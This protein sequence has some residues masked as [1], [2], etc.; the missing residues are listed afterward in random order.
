MRRR[1][2]PPQAPRLGPALVERA[3]ITRIQQRIA[4]AATVKLPA[5]PAL[6]DHYA[7]TCA[8]LFAAAGR[9]FGRDELGAL[10]AVLGERLDAAFRMSSRSHVAIRF[11]APPGQPLGYEVTAEIRTLAD[12]YTRFAGA[13]GDSPF[14]NRADARV[15]DVAAELAS[16]T[17]G[18]CPVLDLGAGTGR[19]AFVLARLGHPVDAVEITPRFALTLTERAASEALGVR[20]LEAD[21]LRDPGPLRRDYRLLVASEVVPD[22]RDV[23]TLRSLFELAAA[24]LLDEGVLLFNVHVVV[25]GY[26]PDRATREF[27]Q[28]CYSMLF[29]ANEIAEAHGGLP[30]ELVANHAVHD[31][32][33]GRLPS[34]AWPPTPWFVNWVTGLDVYDV[35]PHESPI[36][37]RWLTF[38]KRVGCAPKSVSGARPGSARPYSEREAGAPRLDAPSL[39]RGVIRR[40]QRRTSASGQFTFPAVPGLSERYVA[41]CLATFEALGA[42]AAAE[43]AQALR[44][45]LETGSSHAFSQSSRSN[46]TV[47]YEVAADRPLRYGVTAEPVTLAAAYED[48]LEA[49]PWPLFGE[50]AD[51]R[52]LSLIEGVE[53]PEAARILDVGAGLGRNALALGRRGH[54]VDA[55]EMAPGFVTCLSTAVARERLPVRVLAGDF[56]SC[57]EELSPGYWMVLLSGVAGDFRDLAALRQALGIGSRLLAPGGVL[58][59]SIHVA[60]AG[61]IPNAVARAWGQQN[62]ALCV[63]PQELEGAHAGLGLELFADDPL[64]DY[65]RAHLPREAWP[66]TPVFAEWALGQHLYALERPQCP[67]EA[68][69]VVWRRRSPVGGG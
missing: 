66:P 39:R 68:R 3:L 28:Q 47:T 31:Y 55:I 17:P 62:A 4:T 38:R 35:S 2:K 19:N 20:V 61:Y 30:F 52:V 27:S 54:P 37:C 48:W 23:D 9:D 46:V 33:K 43:E 1:G 53:H 40:V 6:A 59:L 15:L 5:V 42:G 22:F 36:S 10:R 13:E 16:A 65:E 63:T 64:Y 50:H 21:V 41:V 12:D 51:A 58:V 18:G 56:F 49:S 14:G 7:Q 8:A 11:Y 44:C 45:A 57:S 25:G 24:V 29:T 34:S 69:W 26:T 67:I 32:E 60:R